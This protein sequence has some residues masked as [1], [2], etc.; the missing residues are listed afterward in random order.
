MQ[1]SY[2]IIVA[3]FAGITGMGS[4]MHTA[5]AQDLTT[6]SGYQFFVTPYLWLASVDAAGARASSELQRQHHRSP[7]ASRWGP[8]YGIVRGALRVPRLSRRRHSPARE[9]QNHDP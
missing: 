3:V 6:P 5:S 7:V 9:H 8:V 2:K 4:G 1:R